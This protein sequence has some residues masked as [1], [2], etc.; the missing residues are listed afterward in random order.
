MVNYMIEFSD[1]SKSNLLSLNMNVP[2]MVSVIIPVY[3]SEM[4]LQESFDSVLK[5]TFKNYEI[6]AVD[7]GSTDR[8]KEI[9]QQFYPM[10]RYIFQGNGGAAKARNTG[11]REAKGD[12][13]AFLDADDIWL[14]TKLQKQIDYFRQHPD[15]DFTF[16]EN[17]LFN[18]KGIIVKTLRKKERLMKGDIVRNIFWKSYV[19]TPTVMVKRRVF[20]EIGKFD[21]SLITA[22]DDNLWLRIAM[23]F[24][25]GLIDEPLVLVRVREKSLTQAEGNIFIGVQNHLNI[26]N[27]KYPDLKERLGSLIKK[28]YSLLYFIRGLEYFRRDEFQESR[29]FFKESLKY[30][31]NNFRCFLYYCLSYLPSSII[32]ALRNT[33]RKILR[34]S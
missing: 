19:A 28:K 13:I 16:T 18:E 25:I 4:Y 8:T 30:S 15:V 6:I 34:L 29:S 31:K 14:P 12:F 24:K 27:T 2:E 22:E 11:I 7:D 26:I 9:I 32:D 1:K 10:V 23:R 21:E 3:N 33:R 17:S 5:Q 20:Q